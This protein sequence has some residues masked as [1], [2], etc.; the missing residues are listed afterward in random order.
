M[1][2]MKF[3]YLLLFLGLIYGY[4]FGTLSFVEV[5]NKKPKASE[6]SKE[7]GGAT[8]TGGSGITYGS[9]LSDLAKSQASTVTESL[10][11]A[12]ATYASS[13][14]A[15]LETSGASTLSA[16]TGAFSSAATTGYEAVVVKGGLNTSYQ[17]RI[18]MLLRSYS[19]TGNEKLL[20]EA[21]KVQK[22]CSSCTLSY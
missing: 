10:T 16:A 7:I 21:Q 9:T 4:L 17:K 15:A 11:S 18:N 14:I 20:K 6:I 22:Q 12:A 5:K 1:Q 2:K 8:Q 19:S 3:I 13:K